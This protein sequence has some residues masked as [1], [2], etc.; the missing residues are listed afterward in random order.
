MLTFRRSLSRKTLK[1]TLNKLVRY[2]LCRMPLHSACYLVAL[3]ILVLLSVLKPSWRGSWC[4]ELL[5]ATCVVTYTGYILPGGTH[6][7]EGVENTDESLF[8]AVLL[9]GCDSIS[10]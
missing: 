1:A 9:T 5:W 3:Q 10:S 7:C 6:K 4:A 2:W 8:T